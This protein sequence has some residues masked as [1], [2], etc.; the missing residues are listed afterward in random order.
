MVPR[1]FF[2]NVLPVACWLGL[3]AVSGCRTGET[4]TKAPLTVK[5]QEVRLEDYTPQFTLTGE[6]VARAQSDLS[7]RV[8]GR[9]IERM[10]DVGSHVE[11][12]GVVARLAPKEQEAD[13]VAAQA[14]L[15][16][17][18]AKL[19]QSTSSFERQKTLLQDGYT[20][21]RAYDLAEQDYRS[22][23]ALLESAKAQ[24]ATAR[25][26][27]AQTT[28][29]SSTAGI[30]TARTLEVGQVV[31]AAQAVFTLAPDG[32]RD[33]VVNVEENIPTKGV[34]GF[35][36]EIAL[37]SDPKI[38]TEGTVREIA[39]AVNAATGTVKVKIGIERLPK[40]MQLGSAIMATARPA[41]WKFPAV[42]WSAMA[43][44]RG[45]PAV[46]VVEPNTRKVMLRRVAVVSFEKS[47]VVIRDGLKQGELVVTAGEQLLR[48]GQ[49]I[50]IS[51]EARRE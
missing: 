46:W 2:S 29:R 49:E 31:Q 34:I 14:A 44:D 9:V 42:P 45:K 28:L 37:V 11:A 3:L 8:S 16:A 26:R 25:D 30:I 21:R 32:A 20:T 1:P 47:D 33:A 18:E 39:P 15:D 51:E 23:Q 19:S 43:S 38:K 41:S 4:N 40:E 50:A 13:V 48:P 10:A 36:V 22:S 35:Q 5:V 12:D 27:L 24:L 6:I 17:A 7:F